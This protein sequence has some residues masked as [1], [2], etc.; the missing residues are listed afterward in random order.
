ML[1][2]TEF[3]PLTTALTVV[4]WVEAIVYLLIGISEIF[5]DFHRPIPHWAYVSKRLNSYLWYLDVK[6]HKM[7]ASLAFL[8]GFVALNGIIEGHV[9]RFEIELIFLSLA[10]LV[11]SIF[12]MALPNRRMVLSIL[13]FAPEF[14]LQIVMFLLFTDLVRPEVIG[15]C[16]ALNGWGLFLFITRTPKIDGMP[17]DYETIRSDMVEGGAPEASVKLY[18]KLVG[19]TPPGAAGNPE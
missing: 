14:V 17:H 12:C 19:Y 10:L 8:L 18:D 5:D 1:T 11:C 15:L 4:L 16:L 13:P 7:H 3:Y 2:A 6:G 9:S